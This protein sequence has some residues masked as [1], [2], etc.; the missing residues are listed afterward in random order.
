MP[1]DTKDSTVAEAEKRAKKKAKLAQVRSRGMVSD[2]LVV[3]DADP[4]MHYEWCRNTETDIDRYRSIGFEVEMGKG[5]GLHG[6]GDG[7]KIVGDA[8]LVACSME[9]FEILEELKAEKHARKLRVSAKKD[10]LTKSKMRNPD[11]PVIDPLGVGASV[12][13]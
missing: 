2:R 13:D 11:V 9:N 5:A 7:R 10:Y 4:K 8:I 1:T 6:K 12:E 3:K